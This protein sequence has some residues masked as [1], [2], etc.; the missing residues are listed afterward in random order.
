MV[1]IYTV[2]IVQRA[3][4][5]NF[6]W[7]HTLLTEIANQTDEKTQNVSNDTLLFYFRWQKTSL[8]MNEP[9]KICKSSQSLWFIIS[10]LKSPF[11][12]SETIFMNRVE[13]R[14]NP[15]FLF[16]VSYCSPELNSFQIFCLK[17][18]TPLSK[19]QKNI[20]TNAEYLFCYILIAVEKQ[21]LKYETM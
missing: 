4:V 6:L 9:N 21:H 1:D 8:E 7:K 17:T 2:S 12:N 15:F 10:K 14:K 13:E 18:D 19:H 5:R 3:S 11:W 16:L 20:Y